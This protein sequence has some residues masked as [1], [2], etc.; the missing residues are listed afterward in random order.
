ML[1][2]IIGEILQKVPSAIEE[3]TKKLPRG[4]PEEIAVPILQGIQETAK[5]LL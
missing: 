3:V 4:F 5:K 1:D 2:E